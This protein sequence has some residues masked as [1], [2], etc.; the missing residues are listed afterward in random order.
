MRVSSAVQMGRLNEAG[1]AADATRSCSSTWGS[2]ELWSS[3]VWKDNGPVDRHH[4]HSALL[5]SRTSRADVRLDS[6]SEATGFSKVAF[7]VGFRRGRHLDS[8]A[9]VRRAGRWRLLQEK[10]SEGMTYSVGLR[11]RP[12]CRSRISNPHC[13]ELT[14][15]DSRI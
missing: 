10:I 14:C 7:T 2:R 9:D 6:R 3:R 1:R 12:G 11:L 15:R 8:L 4:P 13:K 5:Q